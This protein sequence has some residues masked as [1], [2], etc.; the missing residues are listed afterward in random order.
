MSNL[1]ECQVKKISKI[2]LHNRILESRESRGKKS[3][4]LTSFF[5]K[6]FYI[7]LLKQITLPEFMSK[8]VPVLKIEF[9]VTADSTIFKWG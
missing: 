6:I 4:K 8:N 9:V 2:S 3:A 5:R 1:Q 7:F